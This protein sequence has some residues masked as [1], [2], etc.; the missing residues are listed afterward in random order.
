MI[1]FEYLAAIGSVIVLYVLL[2][3]MKRNFF[4]NIRTF[5]SGISTPC[6]ILMLV[7]LIK[8]II[9][10]SEAYAGSTWVWYY[11]FPLPVVFP[12]WS[13][14]NLAFSIL[15]V[16]F[17]GKE[18]PL[19]GILTFIHVHW[20]L[21]N[22][23]YAKHVLQVILVFSITSVA[24]L[25][26]FHF[27]WILLAFSAYPTRSVASQAFTI[28]LLSLT[29]TLFYVIDTL[30][31]APGLLREAENKLKKIAFGAA[32]SVMAVPIII[33][34][35]GVLYYYSQALI[36]INEA[37][38]NPIKTIIAGLAPTLIAAL[39]VWA[40]RKATIYINED[41]SSSDPNIQ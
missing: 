15:V 31:K 33:G 5:F 39:L 10:Y 16:I 34:L 21:K 11:T 41:K 8:D 4:N 1:A 27:L 24:L 40:A 38:N 36:K 7:M 25:V 32:L 12:L 35:S 3:L 28:P 29:L 37:E 14:A 26:S 6:F 17:I 23:K 13:V 2:L 22:N 18:F 20:C 30:A 19:P 9:A